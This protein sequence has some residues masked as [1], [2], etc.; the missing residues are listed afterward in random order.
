MGF[1]PYFVV[2]CER[3]FLGSA[4]QWNEWVLWVVIHG[5][6]FMMHWGALVAIHAQRLYQ[7]FDGTMF[8]VSARVPT[9]AAIVVIICLVCYALTL[10]S[11]AFAVTILATLKPLL[12][13]VAVLGLLIASKLVV[14][15]FI[16]KFYRFNNQMADIDVEDDSAPMLRVVTKSTIFAAISL[17]SSIII[18]G[19]TAVAVRLS[20][21]SSSFAIAWYFARTAQSLDTLTNCVCIYFSIS[22]GGAHYD[23]L[24]AP[25][26]RQCQN[27]CARLSRRQRRDRPTPTPTQNTRTR[28][29]SESKA[30]DTKE[31]ELEIGVQ[32]EEEKE[33]EKEEEKEKDALE[34]MR[35]MRRR[36]S[37]NLSVAHD[38]EQRTLAL[39]TEELPN[40]Q[41]T[42]MERRSVPIGSTL[43]I[44][45]G[46]LTKTNDVVVEIRGQRIEMDAEEDLGGAKVTEI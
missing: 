37:S 13:C 38:F 16:V 6:S 29:V 8:E 25:L 41:K 46:V 2:T 1:V 11:N 18:V 35:R 26:H 12:I 45:V 32:I 14:G 7:V 44:G 36:I 28:A 21:A 20:I 43:Q 19:C 3:S 22:V 33:K 39:S 42:A 23:V 15:A 5:F 10:I 30:Q 31:I 17:I 9:T 40:A 27:G 24:C 4:T 34:A